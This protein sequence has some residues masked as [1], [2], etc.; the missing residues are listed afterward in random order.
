MLTGPSGTG[1]TLLAKATAGETKVSFITVS[2][3]ELFR[4]F[5]GVGPV[6]V[7]G[8]LPL[9]QPQVLCGPWQH[10]TNVR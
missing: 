4:M 10:A 3:S 9:S 7:G 2:G 6:R 5:V 8:C 1:K